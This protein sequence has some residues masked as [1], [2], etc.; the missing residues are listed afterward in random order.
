MTW[1]R[2]EM[3]I[4][5]SMTLAQ[6]GAAQAAAGA[7]GAPAVS[8]SPARA[9]LQRVLG[10]R[11]ADFDF[12]QAAA[13]LP[14]FEVQ[15]HGGRVTVTADSP[16]G[17]L[18][19]AYAYLQEVAALQLNW[20]GDRV[21]LPA[22]WPE[23]HIGRS[24]TPFRHRAY[25]NPCAYGYTAP[26]WDWSRWERELDWMAL[27]G[28]DMP[29]A[30]EGQEFV[31]R[32]LWAEFG[33]SPAELDAYFCGAPFLPWQRMGNIE[34]YGRLPVEWIGKKQRLQQR[35]LARA[36]ELG[37]TPILPGFA[38]YVP[39]ALASRHPK[40][41]L[42]TMTPWGGF[43][44]TCWLDPTDPLF[45]DIARRFH[46]LYAETYGAG[47]HYLADAFNEMRPPV[48][49]STPEQRATILSRYGRALVDA[50]QQAQP[51]AVLAMQGWLFGIDPEF[52]DP[53][54]V[55]AFLQDMPDDRVLMLDIANDT[56]RGVWEKHRAFGGKR[57][58][59]GYIHNFG[60]NNPL[61]GNLPQVQDD[62]ASLP[63]RADKGALQGFGVF[64]EG[65]D[66]NSVV[67]DFMYDAAWPAAGAPRDVDGWLAGW[68]RAR[69]GVD[70]AALRAAWSD[71]WPAVYQVSNWKTA[72]W[73]GAF[74]CYL[75][76][77]RPHAK[78][79]DFDTEPGDLPRLLKAARAL[80]Q[81]ATRHPRAA[82]LRHDVVAASAH[83]G[84]LWVD[85]ELQA[86]L[87][88]LKARDARAAEAHWKA[89]QQQVPAI[90]ALLGAQPVSLARW[91]DTAR[92]Y[93]DTP[94]TA[95]LYV[96]QAR[97]HVSV[98][99]GDAVLNDYASKAWHGLLADFYLPRWTRHVTAAL[100]A[101][102]EQR[103]LDEQRLTD[104][105]IAWEQAWARRDEPVAHRVPARPL[106]A[107]RALLGRL[108]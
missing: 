54:S 72:W 64:P 52:W 15:A 69:Y 36:R 35:I 86:C 92:R 100:A 27:H 106:A 19:G 95:R 82:L 44:E 76:C 93:G 41:R 58:V 65:L 10:R 84:L 89:V 70:D 23:R 101:L 78:F 34:G 83:A 32:R 47:T 85:R 7:A 21:A 18:R 88:A 67:Y 57:W 51:G 107:A 66:T 68:L 13:P 102:R 29:L 103:P 97:L 3:M 99:G 2:R 33:L 25:L 8:G 17:Q 91:T 30:L 1:T 24:S 11:A 16:V 105:L 49:G 6:A 96:E 108:V 80:A 77:K 38:G 9:A 50:L 43:R 79:A 48:Q 71:L 90:D 98:W 31:W 46:A 42:H 5:T 60:G 61:F 37:M 74:G 87:K 59:Y 63:G 45:T 39:K 14:T 53:A 75:L 12:V 26:F 81:A 4:G 56:Y 22:R 28:I 40:A 20:E 94:E 73:N 55:T 62:L 104:E